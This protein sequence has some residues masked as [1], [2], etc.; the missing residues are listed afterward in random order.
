MRAGFGHV[1]RAATSDRDEADRHQRRG[2]EERPAPGDAAEQAAEQRAGGDAEAERGLVEDDRAATRRRVAAPMIT[3]SAV[4]MK[5]ALPR[6]Q[7]ARKPT[8]SPTLPDA[9][10]SALKTMTSASPASS[11]LAR[12]D[13]A[14]DEA[15]DEHRDAGD[16]EVAREQQLDLARR[17]VELLGQRGQ[18]RVD[19]ADA[20]EGDDAGEGDGPDGLGL[21]EQVN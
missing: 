10:A 9:P 5:S 14:G 20:H 12:A 16:R 11:V 18:D 4:A 6:P 7:P 1:A 3:A 2:A 13:A 15:G 21:L 17:G 19:Q 8:I